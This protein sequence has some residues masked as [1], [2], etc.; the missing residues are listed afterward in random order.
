MNNAK[1]I[2]IFTVKTGSFIRLNDPC[3]EGVSCD[4]HIIRDHHIP[5]DILEGV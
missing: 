4:R 1:K 5:S 3:F 2:Q